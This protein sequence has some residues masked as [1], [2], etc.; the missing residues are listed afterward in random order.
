MENSSNKNPYP[1]LQKVY[2]EKII[3]Y[4]GENY[5]EKIKD[6][7]EREIM[8]FIN[9]DLE[10]DE[11]GL[12]LMKKCE[13]ICTKNDGIHIYDYGSF[14]VRN[15]LLPFKLIE[16]GIS[17]IGKEQLKKRGIIYGDQDSSYLMI[18]PYENI[19]L[20]IKD[21]PELTDEQYG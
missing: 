7:T 8:D 13:I 9:L 14:G 18:K 1:S 21:N 10:I 15:G 19:E 16:M 11:D 5:L 17:A 20:N 6:I 12:E 4:Y 2:E 3:N